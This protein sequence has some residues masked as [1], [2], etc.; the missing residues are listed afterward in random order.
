MVLKRIFLF[1]WLAWAFVACTPKVD[2]S[3]K[4]QFYPW[5]NYLNAQIDSLTKRPLK[6]HKTIVL[7]GKKE[8]MN[9]SSIDWKQEWSMFLRADLNT[10]AAA[11]SYENL[12]EDGLIYYLLKS[13]EKLPVKK[14][15]IHLD[16]L[17]RPS[18]VEILIEEKNFLFESQKKLYMNFSGGKVQTYSIDGIQQ[19]R[20]MSPT[21][22]QLLGVL[23]PK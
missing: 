20:W 3:V 21:K 22:F 23:L 4:I 11:S 12:S 2:N 17:E 19:M 7:D 16:G 13:G 18:T 6:V 15:I 1:L 14:L 9:L 8:Q 10:P 5:G